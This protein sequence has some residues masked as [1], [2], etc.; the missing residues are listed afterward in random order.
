[1]PR[2]RRK[3][4]APGPRV[5]S[6]TVVATLMVVE[7]ADETQK[8]P[9]SKAAMG[10]FRG[11][12]VTAHRT[13]SIATRT[14]QDWHIDGGI[15][16]TKHV[17]VHMRDMPI[18]RWTN[19]RRQFSSRVTVPD[20]IDGEPYER[21]V[22]KQK[23]RFRIK[24]LAIPVRNELL[25]EREVTIAWHAA[26]QHIR[27]KAVVAEED[28]DQDDDAHAVHDDDLPAEPIVE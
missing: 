26:R 25:T 28:A 27:R 6:E 17:Y 24:D 18:E 12:V 2:K 16:D 20:T 14:G 7:N 1:M 15:G 4:R 22:R 11:D 23:W 9:G 19:M 21:T 3:A 13:R 8:E 5:N 10:Q